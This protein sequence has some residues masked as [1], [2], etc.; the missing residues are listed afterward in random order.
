MSGDCRVSGKTSLRFGNG[1]R[2]DRQHGWR[3][4]YRVEHAWPLASILASRPR[5]STYVRTFH[6]CPG[7]T[8]PMEFIGCL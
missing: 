6:H 3:H 1:V 5:V 4:G 8:R 7:S 2:V